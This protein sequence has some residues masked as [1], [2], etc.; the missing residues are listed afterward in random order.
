MKKLRK[1]PEG[2]NSDLKQATEIIRCRQGEQGVKRKSW[3]KR[4]TKIRKKKITGEGKKRGKVDECNARRHKESIYLCPV[5]LRA[6]TLYRH[7]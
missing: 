7:I 4:V 2:R 1:S 6:H 5:L 3:Y